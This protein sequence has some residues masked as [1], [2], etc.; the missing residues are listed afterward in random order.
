MYNFKIII[1]F[2]LLKCLYA[3]FS[4]FLGIFFSTYIYFPQM[5]CW[6]LKM[7]DLKR[8]QQKIGVCYFK[9]ILTQKG[10]DPRNKRFNG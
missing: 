10:R 8:I 2:N 5:K 9:Y 7:N 6:K 4:I 1:F 3:E